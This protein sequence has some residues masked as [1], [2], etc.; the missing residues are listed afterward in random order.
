VVEAPTGT[1]IVKR[2]DVGDFVYFIL[3]GS[4]VAGVAEDGHY[5]SLETMRAGDF[6]G[7]IAI[8]MG[9]PRTANV[10]ADEALTALKVPAQTFRALMLNEAMSHV[11]NAKLVARLTKLSLGELP[12]FG[13]VDAQALQ[14]LRAE[15]A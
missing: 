9:T 5:R 6:F 4:A 2:G 14:E 7:E 8:L 13:G 15:P 3:A 11:V 1:Q 12:R 10:V